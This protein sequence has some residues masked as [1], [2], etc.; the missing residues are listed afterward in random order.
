[1][2]E[3]RDVSKVYQIGDERVR[4][5]DHAN[6]HIYPK[7]FVSIIGPSGSGKSTLMNIVGC[8]DVADA[9]IYLLDGMPIEAYSEK[10]LARIRNHKIGFVFQNFN[11]IAKLSAW[12][13]VELPLIYQ[14]V[15]R[16]ERVRRVNEA[17]ERVG[18]SKRAQHLPT[19]LSGGQQQRVAIAR[20]L[21]TRPSLILA[22]EPTGNLDSKTSAEIMA[23]F[24]ELHA[25]G[26]T[27]VLITHDNDVAKQAPRSIRIRDGQLTEVNP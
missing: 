20:A 18:L 10:E 26:N 21:V 15:P 5:L 3:L 4:A 7:E 12:E 2:I 13:N 11:L 6:L 22:D 24:R 9:G 8:L 19:E 25:Q 23:M 14:K 16:A 17:L 1:M 27:I